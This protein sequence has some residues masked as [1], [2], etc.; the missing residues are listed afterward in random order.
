[1]NF[2]GFEAM[3]ALFPGVFFIDVKLQT[4]S[5]FHQGKKIC[6][7]PNVLVIPVQVLKGVKVQI[8]PHGDNRIFLNPFLLVLGKTDPALGLVR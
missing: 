3:D 2:I 5:L 6:C 8:N 7:Y 1:M 4:G